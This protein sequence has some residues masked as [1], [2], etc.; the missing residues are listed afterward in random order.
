MVIFTT[1]P[2]RPGKPVNSASTMV[3][4]TTSRR[5]VS[6]RAWARPSNN[7]WLVPAA[8]MV[9]DI[10]VDV[11]VPERVVPAEEIGRPKAEARKEERAVERIGE[12]AA[13]KR[14]LYIADLTW[15]DPVAELHDH[16]RALRIRRRR[17][18]ARLKLLRYDRGIALELEPAVVRHSPVRNDDERLPLRRRHRLVAR[19]RA[20]D[21]FGAG[22]KAE[23]REP[24]R[25][26]GGKL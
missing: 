13:V 1:S 10:A 26:P 9:F 18:A 6:D 25:G 11:A 14:I 2:L 16:V 5:F 24:H 4:T 12:S 7:G 19:D 22:R 17:V 3:G 21:G 15:T 23:R 8:R 20:R